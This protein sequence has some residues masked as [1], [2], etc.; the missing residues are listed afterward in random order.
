VAED[1]TGD[2]D[3]IVRTG[4][5]AGVVESSTTTKYEEVARVQAELVPTNDMVP[6]QVIPAYVDTLVWV[7]PDKVG[8]V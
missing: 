6:S 4:G 2:V 1:N 8:A 7:G 3:L 5:E